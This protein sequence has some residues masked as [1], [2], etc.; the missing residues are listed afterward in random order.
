MATEILKL[1]AKTCTALAE[2][3]RLQVQAAKDFQGPMLVA[4]DFL[5]LDPSL[6][7]Q[8]NFD[9]GVITPAAKPELFTPE[10]E[11]AGE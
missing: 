5:G 9:T 6:N 3:H 4:L 8:I 2:L 7:H 11:K 1:P 10:T